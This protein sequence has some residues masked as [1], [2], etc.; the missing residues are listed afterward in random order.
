MIGEDKRLFAVSA[1]GPGCRSAQDAVFLLASSS[2]EAAAAGAAE[3]PELD[4]EGGDPIASVFVHEAGPHEVFTM[5]I[6]VERAE[7]QCCGGA[8]SPS[9]HSGFCVEWSTETPVA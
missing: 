3:L 5:T 9:G 1:F 8:A 6:G 7:M 2:A 4:E